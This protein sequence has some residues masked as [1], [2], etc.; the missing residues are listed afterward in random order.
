MHRHWFIKPYGLLATAYYRGW[1]R[2]YDKNKIE[3]P[4]ARSVSDKQKQSPYKK[5]ERMHSDTGVVYIH[6]FD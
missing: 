5:L 1:A 4:L 6:W 3:F 2:L